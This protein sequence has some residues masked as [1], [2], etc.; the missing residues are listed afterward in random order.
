[1]GTTPA[2]ESQT[3]TQVLEPGTYYAFNT[4]AERATRP[5]IRARGRGHGGS[6]G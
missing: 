6:L 3:V 4:G 2:G 5:G 1:M